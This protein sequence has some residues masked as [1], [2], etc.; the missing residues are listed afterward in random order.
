MRQENGTTLPGHRHII[1]D[2]ANLDVCVP[3]LCPGQGGKHLKQFRSEA[4]GSLVDTPR[5][6]RQPHK[7]DQ[8]SAAR[9]LDGPTRILCRRLVLE[10]ETHSTQTA[11]KSGSCSSGWLGGAMSA[12][13]GSEPELLEE[14]A[15]EAE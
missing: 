11:G 15:S 6:N 8:A 12:T 9:V 14:E 13:S 3:S 7:L 5:P 10:L 4:M 1:D 2:A